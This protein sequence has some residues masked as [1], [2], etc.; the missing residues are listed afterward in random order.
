MRDECAGRRPALAKVVQERDEPECDAH[1]REDEP[2]SER[3]HRGKRRA[4]ADARMIVARDGVDGLVRAGVD[5]S[6]E[7]AMLILAALRPGM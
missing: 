1:P 3:R 5:A 6:V 2:Q 4:V 7:E